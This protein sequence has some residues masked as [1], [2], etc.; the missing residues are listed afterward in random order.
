[1]FYIG[2]VLF[3]LNDARLPEKHKPE[4]EG[5]GRV[6]ERGGERGKER[7]RE[8][9]ERVSEE[10]EERGRGEEVDSS[11][12]PYIPSYTFIYLYIPS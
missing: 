9:A 5:R 3:S 8:N 7:G 4:R 12:I 10:T 6:E 11:D 2:R 1:M